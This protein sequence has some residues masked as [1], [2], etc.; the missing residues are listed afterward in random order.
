ML[1]V[2][3]DTE[4]S[5]LNPEKHRIL[6]IAFKIIDSID[7]NLVAK[8]QSII[9]QPREVWKKADPESLEVNEFTWEEVSSGESESTVAD[10]ITSLFNKVGVGEKDGVF[11]CQNPSFDRQSSLMSLKA[12][13]E[14]FCFV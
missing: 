8:Y 7:G 3:L 13:K 14:V 2:F 1:L 4:T 10:E 5:G 11:I 9:S 6:E 12:I